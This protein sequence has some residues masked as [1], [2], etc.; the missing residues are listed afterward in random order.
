MGLIEEQL[1][2]LMSLDDKIEESYTGISKLKRDVHSVKLN[3]VKLSFE[4][5]KLKP[6]LSSLTTEIRE[7]NVKT[8][9]QL[10]SLR[11]KFKVL[12]VWF[13]VLGAFIL[14]QCIVD[15]MS[16]RRIYCLQR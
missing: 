4:V 5:E 1:E 8:E 13:V 3:L 7:Q 6:Q 10:S 16:I 14:Q 12:V 11:L 15:S 9:K 2:G